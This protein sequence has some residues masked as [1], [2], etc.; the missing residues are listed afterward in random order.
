MFHTLTLVEIRSRLSGC[1]VLSQMQP[2]ESL[3]VKPI[4]K[5]ESGTQTDIH[6]LETNIVKSY[7]WNEWELRRKAIHLVRVHWCI[8]F[9][10]FWVYQEFHLLTQNVF[11]IWYFFIF[12][13]SRLISW[14]NRHTQHRL[15]WATWDGKTSLRHGCPRTLPVKARETVRAT[16]PNLRSTWQV[17]EDREMDKW[18]RQTWPDLLMNNIVM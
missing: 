14:P 10:L 12:L 11:F 3:L 9:T 16:C 2:G 15:I 6:P 17:W 7:E 18:S 13:G 5:C 8:T 1:L 4:T